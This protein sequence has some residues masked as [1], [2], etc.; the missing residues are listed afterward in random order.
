[1]DFGLSGAEHVL[2]A[3]WDMCADQL[4]SCCQPVERALP[5]LLVWQGVQNVSEIFAPSD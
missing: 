2:A 5:R 3:V 1:M 4:V